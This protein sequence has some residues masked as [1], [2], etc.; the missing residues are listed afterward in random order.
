MICSLIECMILLLFFFDF[1]VFVNV[2]ILCKI[3]VILYFKVCIRWVV[4]MWVIVY[5]REFGFLFE[6]NGKDSSKFINI[7]ISNCL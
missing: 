3:Y 6:K 5:L 7:C 1:F 2:V 4:I